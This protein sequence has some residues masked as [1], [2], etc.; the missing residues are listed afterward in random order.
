MPLCQLVFRRSQLRPALPWWSH[1]SVQPQGRVQVRRCH[2]LVRERAHRSDVRTHLPQGRRGR[3]RRQGF[4]L[5]Q[6]WRCRVYM[7][8]R[9]EGTTVHHRVPGRCS[10]ALQGE[11][12]VR[13]GWF[14]HVPGRVERG[15]LQP[16]MP[17]LQPFPLQP[18]WQ[19]HSGSDLRVH[20]DLQGVLVRIRVPDCQRY[21]LR[22]EGPVQRIWDLQL[23]QGLQRARLHARRDPNPPLITLFFFFFSLL[24]SLPLS[25]LCSMTLSLSLSLSLSLYLISANPPRFHS[26][27]SQSLRY[28]RSDPSRDFASNC[29]PCTQPE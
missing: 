27:H 16:R 15:R 29:V 21:S 26:V 12:D 5:S 18:A 13:A 10:K 4:L 28:C 2:V 11:G 22:G 7:S 25:S 9:M 1:S 8:R 23:Q 19:M 3:M 14:V 24:L 17:W 20:S 6:G